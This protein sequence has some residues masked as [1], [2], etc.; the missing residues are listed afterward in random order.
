MFRTGATATSTL[1][2]PGIWW[3]VPLGKGTLRPIGRLGL[4]LPVLVRF[5]DILHDRLRELNAAFAR[6]MAADDYGGQFT[7]VYP[8]KVNQQRS[9]VAEI[10]KH[11]KERVGLEAGSKPELVAVL[12]QS[13]SQGVVVCNGYKDREYVQPNPK[14]KKPKKVKGKVVFQP[15]RAPK[16][17]AA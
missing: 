12:A 4:A 3:L 13:R 7:A 15:L 9:V 10:L 16:P 6:A 2:L 8:I 1:T 17:K 11:E 5:S 14:P